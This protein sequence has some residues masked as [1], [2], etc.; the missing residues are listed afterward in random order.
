MISFFKNNPEL[1]KLM[2]RILA[3]VLFVS[4]VYPAGGT[5]PKSKQMNQTQKTA[6]APGD[7]GGTGINL[8]VREE[9]VTI[10]YDCAE[11]EI[12]EKLMIDS[13][14]NFIVEGTYIRRNP[15]AIRLNFK[16]KPLAAKFEGKISGEE[17]TLKVILTESEEE[18]GDYTLEKDK[19][20]RLHRCR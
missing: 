7:W 4:V 16:P 9:G 20:A 12:T 10:E 15:G 14:G 5:I 19:T 2:P 13:K 11:A 17:M 8:T 6:V 3:V 1:V 18:I